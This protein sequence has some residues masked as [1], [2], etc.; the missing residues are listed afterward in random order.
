MN[1]P[2]KTKSKNLLLWEI[3]DTAQSS[4]Y[5][6]PELNV[7][8]S[9]KK[10]DREQDASTSLKIPQHNELEIVR[11]F[12]RLAKE[13][14]S[15][16]SNMYPLGCCTM[17]Y[18][19]RVSEVI[20]GAPGFLSMHPWLSEN[21]QGGLQLL[22]ELQ[23]MLSKM[24]GFDGVSLTPAAG[25]HGELCGV[26]MIR[27]YHEN[28]GD[29]KRK[30][31]V[32]P[33]T[34]HGTNPATVSMCGM[35]VLTVPSDGE[36]HVDLKR[37]EELLDENCAGMMLTNPNTLGIFETSVRDICA[38]VHK[39]GGLMYADGANF[40]AIAGIVKPA[41]LGFDVMHFNLHKTFGTP[42]GGGGPGAGPVGCTAE[43]R[44][45]LPGPVVV[46][47]GDDEYAPHFPEK[48]IGRIKTGFGNVGILLRAYAYIKGHGADGVRRNSE[49][50]VLKANYLRHLLRKELPAYFSSP[51]MHEFVST[52]PKKDF[53]T[54]MDIAKALLDRGFH[55]PTVYFPLTVKEALMVE[56]TESESFE[57]IECFA[58]A[59]IEILHATSE[60]PEEIRNTPVST[61]LNRLDEVFAN[62]NPVLKHDM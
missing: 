20:A 24:S 30:N 38:M 45:Y 25:A 1:K 19:P 59:L 26:M 33:D 36:G 48:S 40:N 4:E 60:N 32:V 34:A 42:H 56:P 12:T 22:Y 8:D 37:L 43:L 18:N 6:P 9:F 3:T 51:S 28:K 46:R 10:F 2:E 52:N 55:A 41:E 57:E 23:D 11:H 7:P 62:R 53:V 49:M 13:N 58:T 61:S 15:I 44:D 17:K 50:A 54:T 29:T 47:K 5:F 27:K 21:I 39:A 35:N 14:Y 31:I 16:D